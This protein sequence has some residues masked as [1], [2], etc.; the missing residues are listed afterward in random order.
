MK[1][2]F[3]KECILS[4]EFDFLLRTTHRCQVDVK[5]DDFSGFLNLSHKCSLK[6]WLPWQQ[7]TVFTYPFDFKISPINFG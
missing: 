7:G 4:D 5:N 2:N 6:K 3:V 1:L